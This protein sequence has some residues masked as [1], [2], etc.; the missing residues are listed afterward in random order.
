MADHSKRAQEDARAAQRAGQ[1]AQR[2][3]DHE[4][5]EERIEAENPWVERVSGACQGLPPRRI[6]R[7]RV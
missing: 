1:Q 4:E 5:E 6:V 3:D 2:H 7:R